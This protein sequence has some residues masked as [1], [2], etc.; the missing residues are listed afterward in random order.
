MKDF[1]IIIGGE[2]GEGSKKAGMIIA[3]FFNVYGFNVFIHEDYQSLIKGGHNFSSISVSERKVDGVREEVD[4][5][6]ALNEDTIFKHKNKIKKEGGVLI[7]D[8]N[9]TDK[10]FSAEGFKVV[11][12][13][14][15]EIVKKVEGINLMKNTALVSSFAKIIG[16]KWEVIEEVLGKELKVELEK[17]IEVAKLAF[18]ETETVKEV[19]A[20]GEK[21]GE[22]ISGNEAVALGAVDAG[23][24]CFFAYPMTPATGIL[25]FFVNY[26]KVKTF[27]PENEISVANMVLGAG[28]TG[29]RTM[30]GTSGGGFALMTE[31]LSLSAQSETP[32]VV[33]LSQRMGPASGVPTYQGQGDLL[34][35]LNAGHGDM[36]R[37]VVA[38]GDADDAYYL[39]GEALNT[40]WKYQLPSIIILDKE[41]SEN[42]YTFKK[43]KQVE[44][45]EALLAE[46]NAD[47]D[48]YDGEDISPMAFPGGEAV[49]K[50]T[51]YEHDKKGV[52]TEDA[53]AIK[54]MQEKRI[55]KYEK[56]RQ[57]V[58]EMETVRVT[59]SGSVAVVFWGSTKGAVLEAVKDLEIKAIQVLIMEPFSKKQMK[60]ALV[61]VE[62]IISIE[63]NATG[64]LSKVLQC[65]G[66]KVDEE[67][68]KYNG[69]P[70]SVDELEE[71]LK[72]L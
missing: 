32:F 55:R 5:V 68:L 48:R 42:T 25:R 24:E 61:G 31:A 8:E 18:Q 72:D 60:E 50:A 16:L 11:K 34:F 45:R 58:E 67:I 71:K 52:V 39:T 46:N 14:L 53:E 17:N 28:Y 36:M 69:R 3:N 4:F 41:I 64:Q 29:K 21:K 20:V 63:T 12:V 13:P 10:D 59:G 70:F 47:Y 23:L 54:K 2:A 27:Q 62:K 49:V 1:Q 35:A 65:N 38:P 51:S 56:L 44:K 22:L 33:A 57:E 43:E 26:D 6:L 30:T 37:F 66:F 7:Y 40:A 15:M 9:C 19:E